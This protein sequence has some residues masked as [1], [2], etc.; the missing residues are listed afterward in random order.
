MT[1]R[2]HVFTDGR[3]SRRSALGLLGAAPLGAAGTAA[4]GGNAGARASSAS[5]PPGSPPPALLPGGAFEKYVS[6]LAARDQFSGTVLLAR[7]GE[8]VLVRGYQQANKERNIPNQAGTIFVLASL[9]KFFT[10][11]AV[12]QLAAQGKVDFSATVGTYVGGLPSAIADYVTVHELLTHTSGVP[13][14]MNTPAYQKLLQGWTTNTEAFNGTLQ[15]IQGLTD[16]IVSTPGTT[17]NYT[18]TD[19]FLAG[20]VVAGASGQDLWDYVPRHI[21][22]PARMTSTGFYTSDQLV[23]DPRIAHNYGPPVTGGQRQDIT[24]KIS[25]G[26]NG[27]NGAG[28][29]SSS[30]TDLLR[31][32]RALGDGTL[33]DPAWAE[34]MAAGKYPITSAQHNPDQPP[35]QS[36]LVGYGTDE[37]ITGGQRAFGHTGG[38][39]VPV[40]GSPQPGGGSTA[41]T[42][43]PGLGVTAVVLSNY[44]LYPGIG[45]F[46]TEQ[47]RIITAGAPA[48]SAFVTFVP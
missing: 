23:N 39:E 27:W 6:G 26:P 20:A 8:P 28:G 3:L 43:Y 30:A 14:I 13:E 44:F 12:T 17:Y 15:Y 47:D 48:G 21:F 4:L 32:A 5:T 37:R 29:A 45:T 11:L 33:L 42:I 31:F 7:H 16:P 10:G 9:T 1:T 19:Y 35:A 25:H 41:L 2:R 34:L 46:L 18:N 40:S 24:Q 38:M 22:S 36:Y